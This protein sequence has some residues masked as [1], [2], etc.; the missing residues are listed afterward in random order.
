MGTWILLSVLVWWAATPTDFTAKGSADI[1]DAD[2]CGCGGEHAVLLNATTWI[3][4]LTSCSGWGWRSSGSNDCWAS[5]LPAAQRW[6][7]LFVFVFVF[8]G[9]RLHLLTEHLCLC[10]GVLLSRRTCRP[11]LPQKENVCYYCFVCTFVCFLAFA[12]YWAPTFYLDTQYIYSMD[13]VRTFAGRDDIWAGPRIFS[14]L[15]ED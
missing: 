6:C 10:A 7:R 15:F 9:R 8:A 3:H 12:T 11:W 13:K 2:P 4:R 14:G 1:R 5:R